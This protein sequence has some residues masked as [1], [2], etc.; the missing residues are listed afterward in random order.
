MERRKKDGES[1]GSLKIFLQARSKMVS[2]IYKKKKRTLLF[3][4]AN[5]KF[6]FGK[7]NAQAITLF[8]FFFLQ[9]DS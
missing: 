6:C 4:Y 5:L 2:H 7:V 1:A 3:L 8:F 9:F